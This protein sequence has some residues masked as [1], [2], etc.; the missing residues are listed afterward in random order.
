MILA[1]CVVLALAIAATG[2]ARLVREGKALKGRVEAYRDLP[3]RADIAFA[4]SRLQ[5][6][7]RAVDRLP[8]FANRYDRSIAEL[9]AARD[10][11]ITEANLLVLALRRQFRV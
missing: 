7:E 6:A 10:L 3:L 9:R 5:K 11:V 8:V 4:V 1:A 2:A